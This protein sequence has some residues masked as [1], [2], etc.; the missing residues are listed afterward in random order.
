[1]RTRYHSDNG[2]P[3]WKC[4]GTVYTYVVDDAV[5][6]I[7]AV[8]VTCGGDNTFHPPYGCSIDT[9]VSVS[10]AHRNGWSAS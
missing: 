5:T 7:N 10:A 9:E 2:A 4:S 3:C 1:M 6:H 8:C